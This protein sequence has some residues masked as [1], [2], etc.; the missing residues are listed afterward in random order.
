M[1]KTMMDSK[2]EKR[3]MNILIVGKKKMDIMIMGWKMDMMMMGWKPEMML[4]MD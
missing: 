1:N 3:S 4:M 2:M